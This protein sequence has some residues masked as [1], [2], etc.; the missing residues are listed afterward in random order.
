MTETLI[1][2]GVGTVLSTLWVYSR[3]RGGRRFW[4]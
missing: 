1:G 3:V 2:I 4:S